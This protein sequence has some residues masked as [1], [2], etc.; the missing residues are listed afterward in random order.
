MCKG[1]EDIMP[2]INQLV[3]KRRTDKT[4]KSKSPVLGIGYNS[5]DKKQTKKVFNINMKI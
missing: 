1:K 2:T 5:K 4:R 3:R